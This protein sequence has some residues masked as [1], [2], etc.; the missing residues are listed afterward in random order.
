MTFN[1]L[2][3]LIFFAAVLALHRLPLPWRGRKTVLLV[4]SYL[5][6]AAWSPPFV[7]LLIVSTAVDWVAA[8]RIHRAQG[9][10]RGAWLLLSLGVNLGLLSYFKYGPFL[11]EVTHDLLASADIAFNPASD[12]IV[13]PMGISFYTF[14]TLSYTIDVYRGRLQPGRSLLDY[15]L[16]VTFFPQLVAGPIV[17]AADFLPQCHEPKRAG[18]GQVGYGLILLTLGLLQKT[19]FADFLFAPVAD[20][21]FLQPAAA[22]SLGAWAGCLAFSGQIFCDFA[23][24]ST[25]GIGVALC[26][27]FAL[28]DNFRA[29]YAAIG[30]S[31]FWRRWHISL[32]S[33]LRDYLYIPLGG[34][35]GGSLRQARNLLVTMLLGGLW[36]GAAWT[37]VAWGALHGVLLVIEH[38]AV[39]AFGSRAVWRRAG[40]QLGL[41]ALTFL[42]ITLAWV[43][44]RATSFGDA[45]TVWAALIGGGPGDAP[46]HERTVPALVGIALLLLVQWRMRTTS[47]EALLATAPRWLV[48]VA[49]AGALFLMAVAHERT[50]GFLY[51]QF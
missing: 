21:L 33:W 2:T 11:L 42:L 32:S 15:A 51:F 30:F 50:R 36:H 12:G 40:P 37:F 22:G 7:A 43:P 45:G 41:A 20:R 39:A 31:D 23:G 17:R 49:I 1:S 46:L 5:F 47:L 14:Q 8:A 9:R 3:F 35:R 29:P 25:C 27:G 6:Y 26:L 16:Y 18:A 44:F 10:A 13:L 24:Y 48:S 38:A 19:V 34:N 28:P 4:A